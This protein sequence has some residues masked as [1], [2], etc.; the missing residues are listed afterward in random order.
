MPAFDTVYLSL[1]DTPRAILQKMAQFKSSRVQADIHNRKRRL[2][3]LILLL[4]GIG[5]VAFDL[6][7]IRILLG[8]SICLLTPV[9]FACWVAAV[10]VFVNLRWTKSLSLPPRYDSA[11]EIIKTLQD[12]IRTGSSFLGHIDLT[13]LEQKSKIAR[14]NKDALGRTSLLYRDPWLNLKLKLYDGNILRLSLVERSKT[15]LGYWKRSRISGKNKWKPPKHKGT[16]HELN[17]RLAVNQDAYSVTIPASLRT[18][19][20]LGPFSIN[21]IDTTGGILTVQ[22]ASSVEPT[23]QDILVMLR[24][25]YDSLQR[26]AAA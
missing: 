14:E 8:Y 7:V 23:T 5:C 3:P 25:I 11:G 4:A 2:I 15:R 22:A 18:G 6:L 20:T 13:G 21:R 12:D 10:V 9:A 24:K 16:L 1:S 26:K 17:V 19:T